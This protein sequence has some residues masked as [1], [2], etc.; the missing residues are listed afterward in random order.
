MRGFFIF[1]LGLLVILPLWAGEEKL[2][3]FD[4]EF[5]VATTVETERV[6]LQGLDA[7]RQDDME[8]A[9]QIFARLV[10][11][12]PE[13]RLAQLVYG[14]L[15]M[16]KAGALQ[17][18]GNVADP[19]GNWPVIRLLEEALARTR[20]LRELPP[21]SAVPEA[22][23]HLAN[24]ISH[25]IVID[26]SRSR[27]YLFRNHREVP[28]LV[29]DYYVSSGIN[30]ADKFQA[31]DKRTPIGVY[32]LTGHLDGEE[33]PDFYGPGGMPLNYPN[34]WDRS[35]GKSGHGI[36]IHGTP[37]N[38]YSRPPRASEGCVALTNP[39]FTTLQE[40]LDA[41]T[42]VVIAPRVEWLAVDAW[43]ARK[44]KFMTRVETWS[45]DY[46]SGRTDRISRHY[47]QAYRNPE[48]E[49]IKGRLGELRQTFSRLSEGHP[50]FSNIT[51]LGYPANQQE[52]VVVSYT[53]EFPE[54][55]IKQR[56]QRR[57]YWRQEGEEWKIVFEDQG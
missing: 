45:R 35:L 44:Q 11:E 13:Y 43:R 9:N 5:D 40:L 15:L 8:S 54:S 24:D 19:S 7:I 55:D 17:G 16:A 30:G 21:A 6:L 48:G 37:V 1:L 28:E 41:G 34:G 57:Q 29:S 32:F 2:R 31:G 18:F 4:S 56:I 25:A 10:R 14:D 39:D 36:W 51:I 20:Y 38:T 33:L 23:L 22:L 42:P 27:L 52:M 46:L 49:D 50:I 26:L 47:S 53:E 3:L 12:H